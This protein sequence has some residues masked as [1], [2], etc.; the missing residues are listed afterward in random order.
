MK[1]EKRKLV[2]E[3]CEHFGCESAAYDA[4]PNRNVL[5]IASRE[6]VF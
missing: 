3:Y 1:F 4:E 5:A 2:H 6:K